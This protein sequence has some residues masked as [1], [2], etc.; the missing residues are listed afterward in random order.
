MLIFYHKDI[1][2]F[3]WPVDGLLSYSYTE[4]SLLFLFENCYLFLPCMGLVG[5]R[6]FFSSCGAGT[7]RKK[8]WGFTALGF[9]CCGAL[10][11]RACGFSSCGAWAS[12]HMWNLLDQVG[13]SSC[14]DRWFNHWTTMEVLS[15]FKGHIVE[16]LRTWDLE[17]NRLVQVLLVFLLLSN[18]TVGK[19]LDLLEPLFPVQLSSQS[20]LK[21][22]PFQTVKEDK[23]FVLL[24]PGSNTFWKCGYWMQSVTT[25]LWLLNSLKSMLLWLVGSPS[26]FLQDK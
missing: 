18:E 1:Y 20:S 25:L 10:G 23:G 21:L 6:G 3:C 24:S 26:S 16:L 14:I 12:S 22:C 2:T 11:S 13:I 8:R 4:H 5:A 19:S 9:S 7:L 15:A 17:L